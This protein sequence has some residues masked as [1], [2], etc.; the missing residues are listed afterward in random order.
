LF[1]YTGYTV[2]VARFFEFFTSITG[3]AV[4]VLLD[5]PEDFIASGFIPGSGQSHDTSFHS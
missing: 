5:V 1:P 3:V 2:P 4:E